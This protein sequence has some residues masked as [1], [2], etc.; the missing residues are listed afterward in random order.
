MALVLLL[1]RLLVLVR[2]VR[3]L[4][5]PVLDRARVVLLRR[6]PLV[7]VPVLALVFLLLVMVPAFR[8]PVT[9]LVSALASAPALAP[10]RLRL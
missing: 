5:L 2:A 3:R 4:R 1:R 7:W 8:L 9:V 10:V 6:R